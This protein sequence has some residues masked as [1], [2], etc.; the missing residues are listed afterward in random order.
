G[1]RN[2][3]YPV[4]RTCTEAPEVLEL[5]RAIEFISFANLPS[6]KVPVAVLHGIETQRPENAHRLEYAVLHPR[7]LRKKIGV[8]KKTDVVGFK[9]GRVPYQSRFIDDLAALFSMHQ[10]TTCSRKRSPR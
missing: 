7:P 6:V 1:I 8:W 2:T 5:K 10:H 4:L 3:E 9:L